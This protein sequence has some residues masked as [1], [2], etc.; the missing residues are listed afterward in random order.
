LDVKVLSNVHITKLFPC[1]VG[2]L[3]IILFCEHKFYSLKNSP[4]P[5]FGFGHGK[6]IIAHINGHR[7]FNY[8]SS[9]FEFF[10]NVSNKGPISFFI[11]R[12]SVFPN[13]IYLFFIAVLSGS[14]LWHLQKS[15]QYNK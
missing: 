15:L 14:T 7:V 3:I 10:Y 11:L 2:S 13:T 1:S 12:I 9:S 5:I 6:K 8:F 4:L